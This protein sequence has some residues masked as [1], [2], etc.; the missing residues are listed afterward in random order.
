MIQKFGNQ[1]RRN[2]DKTPSFVIVR[3][4]LVAVIFIITGTFIL[5]YQSSSEDISNLKFGDVAPKNILAPNQTV[6]TSKI[7]TDDT[8]RLAEN[9]V[10][11]IYTTPD[12]NVARK[13][14][15]HLRAIF[16]FLDT[17]RADP[18]GTLPQ[19]SEWV[20]SISD[21]TLSNTIIDE[22]L[23]TS[24][25]DWEDSKREAIDLLDKALRDE[26]R[27][28]QVRTVRRRLENQVPLDTPETQAKVIVAL[29][30][31]LIEPNTFPDP[32]RTDE[33]KQVEVE[34]VQ[35]VIEQ[36]EKNELIISQGQIVRSLHLE[37]LEAVGLLNPQIDQ[38]QL[39]IIPAFL[40]IITTIFL[41]VYF[42]QYAPQIIIDGK[43]L[44]LLACLVLL[45]LAIA[46]FIIPQTT[47]INYTYSYPI[48]TLSMIV[49][50]LIDL[51]LTFVLI[52]IVA[53][54]VGYLATDNT[55]SI[56]IYMIL[57]GW[58]GILAL[59]K[60]RRVSAPIWAGLY[61]I[62]VNI[63]AI[64][65]FSI[66]QNG[67][68]I[69]NNLGRDL[70]QGVM[71]GI[72][73]GGLALIGVP[74]IGRLVGITT[75]MQ[76]QELTRPTHP[77]LRQLLLKAPGT[78]H[79]SLM[80]SNLAEQAAE[81][82]GADALLVRVMAYY[83][84]IGK[85]QRPYFFVE[86]QPQGVNVHEKLDPKVS[87]QIIISHAIDGLELAKKYGLPRVIQ[88][89][90]SQH[91]GTTLVKFF[92]YQYVKEAN[93]KNLQVNEDDFRYPGPRPQNKENGILM[94]ADVTESV[95][96]ALKPGSA[97]EIDEIVQKMIAEKLE[98]G[99]LN[100]CDLT[101]ADLHKI[102]EAFV[103]ILQGVHHPRIKYPDPVKLKKNNGDDDVGNDDDSNQT[104]D[105]SGVENKS[106]SLPVKLDNITREPLSKVE[107][108]EKRTAS[109]PQAPPSEPIAQPSK[110]VRRE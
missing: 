92:F 40:L 45:F 83:H 51:Q 31:S 28:T 33:A 21:L 23:I 98:M 97:Q 25:H 44:I 77:L 87:A 42:A 89:G 86:N 3:A 107:T 79:H 57:S 47:A 101:I 11:T 54:H 96:R 56:V 104:T 52:T 48:A 19:K 30:G 103:D 70:L 109:S 17:V 32:T 75:Q 94:L 8:R 35:D 63:S 93:E 91:H 73:S 108:K 24:D 39:Y 102:R 4:V 65:V 9:S 20:R 80:V 13:Q 43:R 90:I 50:I 61:V 7:K 29:A 22:I 6:Y 58:T 60:G 69:P 74:T 2:N 76:L 46:R 62:L 12:L 72:F 1:K 78:Y 88:D 49:V 16:D 10:S 27:E 55:L 38:F 99:Q 53:L 84:D 100:D 66:A 110:L 67:L 64:L 26:I 36:L 71:N 81:R 41:G 37:K 68:S 59:N 15:K 106:V 5:A 105:T 82:V 34:K 18:Y 95:V 85:M 14:V